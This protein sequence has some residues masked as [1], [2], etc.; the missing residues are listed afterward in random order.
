[1]LVS[2]SSTFVF[3]QIIIP[4]LSAT[5]AA[6]PVGVTSTSTSTCRRNI[7]TT[8]PV[9]RPPGSTVPYRV[10]T[11]EAAWQPS[12]A[13]PSSRRRTKEYLGVQGSSD[14]RPGRTTGSGS[15]NEAYIRKGKDLGEEDGEE[16]YKRTAALA[17]ERI[18]KSHLPSEQGSGEKG[19]GKGNIKLGEMDMG[20]GAGDR[21]WKMGNDCKGK[22]RMDLE[23]TEYEEGAGAG[24]LG[25]DR[26]GKG[27]TPE[28][29]MENPRT[30]ESSTFNH[31]LPQMSSKSGSPKDVIKLNTQESSTSTSVQPD[32]LGKI[33]TTPDGHPF[34]PLIHQ[35]LQGR[36]FRLATLHIL[37]LPLYALDQSLIRRVAEYM[38]RHGA[39][40]SAKRLRRGRVPSPH[41]VTLMSGSIDEVGERLPAS[42]WSLLRSTRPIPRTLDDLETYMPGITDTQ[43]R[44]E[45][46]TTFCNI[47]LAKS[48]SLSNSRD[49][50]I[51]KSFPR[52]NPSLRQLRALLSRIH[53]LEKHR[54]F[55]PD[56]VTANIILGSWVKCSLSPR[57][58]GLRIVH[59]KSG[60]PTG[61]GGWKVSPRHTSSAHG[62]FGK[63]E[64]RRLFDTI[65]K[66][67]DRSVLSI[68][69]APG[70]TN[71]VDGQ[72]GISYSRH[73]KPFVKILNRGFT[74]LGDG[75]GKEMVVKW[76]NQVRD[77][78]LEAKLRRERGE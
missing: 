51:P 46:F 30:S 70:V 13:G 41:E 36:Q 45:R 25:E 54:G 10:D 15:G 74:D 27:R 8:S 52:P 48:L 29:D 32:P 34:P 22:G 42:Y 72:E 6:G 44:Q 23:G 39:G 69:P 2:R 43:S 60:G 49:H 16:A 75:E 47:Q 24:R 64:L 9:S 53:K 31:G 11:P 33:M 58:E 4:Y 57:H 12:L 5:R 73:V 71:L 56:R 77:V 26:N 76:E 7:T 28:T 17:L 20:L 35:L 59:T 1:M 38:E 55:V 67:I 14:D 68:S 18:I 66:L 62:T 40:K 37:N 65:S 61:G 63:L 3:S 50:T 78:L 19:K 21:S